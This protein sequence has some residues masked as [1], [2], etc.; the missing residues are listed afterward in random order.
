MTPTTSAKD[1]P[2]GHKVEQVDGMT[3]IQG[4]SRTE[5][6]HDRSLDQLLAALQVDS[7]ADC[8]AGKT[9]R[10]G[11]STTRHVDARRATAGG[12]SR[13]LLAALPICLGRLYFVGRIAGMIRY[14]PSD[15]PA[16]A[17]KACGYNLK[18]SC[19]ADPLRFP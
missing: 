8:Y 6:A 12:S 4:T 13:P 14:S 18:K 15:E 19:A 3:E 17:Q 9:P 2:L 10:V 16:S 11:V 1:C 7:A 5:F